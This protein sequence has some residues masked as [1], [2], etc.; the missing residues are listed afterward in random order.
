M[1][2][3]SSLRKI[4]EKQ[5]AKYGYRLEKS[6]SLN[7]D[8]TMTER[9][10]FVM[11][12]REI[13]FSKEEYEAQPAGSYSLAWIIPPF[14]P[15]LGG[16]R[17]IF[18]TISYLQ[19]KGIRNRIYIYGGNKNASTEDMKNIINRD[20]GFDVGDEIYAS[21]DDMK[22]AHGVVA[23]SWQTAYVLRNFNNCISKFYFVQDFEPYFYPRGSEY[24]LA[25][26]TYRFGFRGITAGHW[27]DE[28]LRDE[29]GMDTCGFGFSYDKELYRVHEKKD[30][31]NRIFLYARPHTERRAFDIAVLALEELARHMEIQVR[32]AGQEFD[33][34]R[35]DFLYENLGVLGLDEMSAVYGQCDF[36]FVLS[37][38]NI[39]LLPTEIM[40]SGS[41]CL[42]NA[43]ENNA[44]M[45][46]DENSILVGS[47]PV[48]IASTMQYYLEHK[49][50][51]SPK[52]KNG[53]S[54]VEETSWDKELE[55]VYNY[56]LSSFSEDELRK[57]KL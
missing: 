35:F 45:V 41:V 53:L 38:T 15:G 52:R 57:E 19:K 24:L 9:Y 1:S 50:Q 36:C 29:Y 26:N 16:H 6:L 31:V 14:G 48:E 56:V 47:D 25:E 22:F 8:E 39:S 5:L 17:T 23:T 43:G 49:E 42:T 11:D 27:L 18:R 55:I 30:D 37:A 2:L 32:M 21:A 10:D 20:Y 12:R 33:G 34:Y 28:K 54:Y 40:A 44:W 13:P 7:S 51:L 46:N 4:L 3:K